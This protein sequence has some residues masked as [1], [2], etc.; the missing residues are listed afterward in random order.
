MKIRQAY[1]A[2]A[3][4]YDQDRNLTR[5][6][7]ALVVKKVLS[8]LR[9]KA[10][11]ELGCGTGKNT[12]LLARISRKVRALDFSSG[13]IAQAKEKV[14]ADHVAF[15][16]ADISKRWPVES[17]SM[18]LAVCNLVLEH[19]EDLDFVFREARRA[20]RPGGRFFVCEL[21]P[22]RQY[23]GKA[24][25]FQNGQGVVKVAAFAHN[26]SDFIAAA[27]GAGLSLARIDEWWHKQDE[28][29]PPRL[30]SFL[31]RKPL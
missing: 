23:E 21:H 8:G 15:T 31:F 12:L 26:I 28:G 13:M 20:L 6:L 29:K 11:L 25:T 3:K 22:Y 4:T 9:P 24:A 30:A 7:D 5:D 1:D 17:S 27:D 2:W 16:P 19:I 14:S 10:A 18:D